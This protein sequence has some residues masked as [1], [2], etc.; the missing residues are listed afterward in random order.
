MKTHLLIFITFLLLRSCT[1]DIDRNIT[2]NLQ[3]EAKKIFQTSLPLEESLRYV[4][5]SFEE[6]QNALNDILP[7]CP[8]ILIDEIKKKLNFYLPITQIAQVKN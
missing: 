4:F 7:G 6:Y 1:N 3:V 5:L 2:K 8:T